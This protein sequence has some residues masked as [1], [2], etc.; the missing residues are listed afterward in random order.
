MY[1]T[2][3]YTVHIK[4]KAHHTHLIRPKQKVFVTNVSIMP[5]KN[6]GSKKG[7]AKPKRVPHA[8]ETPL[9]H[10]APGHGAVERAKNSMWEPNTPSAAGGSS[11]SSRLQQTA[12][13]RPKYKATTTTSISM[14]G[15]GRGGGIGSGSGSGNGGGGI[16]K[17]D[18]TG[19][20]SRKMNK[21]NTGT[22]AAS[23]TSAATIISSADSN[24]NNN[25]TERK[26]NPDSDF[27]SSSK[28]SSKR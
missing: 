26:M 21:I 4:Y 1:H 18:P 11:S 5:P 6:K 8:N 24:T 7:T 28:S 14:M 2:I 17:K 20:A 15:I 13:P 12:P 25:N 16:K 9:K 23:A 19:A 10:K 27:F 22:T 3:P